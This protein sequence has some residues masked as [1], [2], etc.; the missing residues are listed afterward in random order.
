[1]DAFED[2]A[3]GRIVGVVR[4]H[5]YEYFRVD[6]RWYS[7]TLVWFVGRGASSLLAGGSV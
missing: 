6:E 4:V 1:M 3:V 5:V 7:V 2:D